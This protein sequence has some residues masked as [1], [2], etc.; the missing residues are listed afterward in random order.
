MNI[1]I[2]EGNATTALDLWGLL[3]GQGHK[4]CGVVR[5]LGRCLDQL[6]ES[7]PDLV[8]LDDALRSVALGP[9]AAEAIARTGVPV[10][11]VGGEGGGDGAA[12]GASGPVLRRPFTDERLASVMARIGRGARLRRPLA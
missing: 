6:A 12:E 4:V 3:H 7:P 8:I 11:I 10:L 1:L 5:D 9:D 2:Y